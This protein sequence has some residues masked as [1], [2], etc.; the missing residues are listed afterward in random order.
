MA[1][2]P[3]E[4]PSRGTAMVN[5]LVD[6]TVIRYRQED[7]NGSEGLYLEDLGALDIMGVRLFQYEGVFVVAALEE[8][9]RVTRL[10]FKPQ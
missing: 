1:R 10:R 3:D 4:R 8:G 5:R 7:L 2:V 6:L 9:V